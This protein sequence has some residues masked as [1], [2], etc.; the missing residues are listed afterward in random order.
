MFVFLPKIQFASLH[1]IFLAQHI[2]QVCNKTVP[3][4]CLSISKHFLTVKGLWLPREAVEPLFLEIPESHQDIST[5]LLQVTLLELT[6]SGAFQPPPFCD[7]LRLEYCPFLRLLTE[8]VLY[9][10]ST[11]P[12]LPPIYHNHLSKYST[13][14]EI[15]QSR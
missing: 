1:M 5:S 6:S 12:P 13:L 10:T 4:F 2:V 14:Q 8:F 3:C 9:A 15:K 7:S 11:Y